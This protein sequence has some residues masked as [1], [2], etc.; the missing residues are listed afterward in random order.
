MMTCI[1][2]YSSCSS[3]NLGDNIY[4]LDGDRKEDRIIVNCTGKS[5]GD[6]ITGTYLIP[7]K[8]E[9]HFINGRYSEYVDNAK[10]NDDYVIA[11][12]VCLG[13]NGKPYWI[14]D[15]KM[16]RLNNGESNDSLFVLGPFALKSFLEETKRRNIHLNL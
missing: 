3:N 6:C 13:S 10:A 12:T 11:S 2:I 4:L 7:R 1:A 15:K 14:I 8:Y 5:F 9:E 16:K